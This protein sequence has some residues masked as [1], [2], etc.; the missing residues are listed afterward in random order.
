MKR[1]GSAIWHGNIREGEGK[2]ST[3]SNAINNI[4]YSF[5]MRF[6]K[7][8]GTNPEELIGAAHA[9]CFSMALAAQLEKQ[10]IKPEKI[11]TT[12][13][14]TLEKNENGFSIPAI[15]LNVVAKASTQ[16]EE[17]EKAANK[18]KADC[19]VSKLMNA[20]VTLEAEL[21]NK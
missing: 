10:G 1:S 11:K 7:E 15:H 2:I 19:P 17:F 9:A 12:A 14:V 13:T 20:T 3:E 21:E 16:K 5:K 4:P 6:E 8:N 18:A